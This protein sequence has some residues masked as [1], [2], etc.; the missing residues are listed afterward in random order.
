M[1]GDARRVKLER[2][3]I[4][5]I[6]DSAFLIAICA[7]GGEEARMEVFSVTSDE[8]QSDVIIAKSLDIAPQRV[9]GTG[10]PS[11]VRVV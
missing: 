8:F 1:E 5:E 11:A 10:D 6:N 2:F 9:Q 7:N 4:L 3:N